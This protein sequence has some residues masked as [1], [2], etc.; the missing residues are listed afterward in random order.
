[1]DTHIMELKL[2][3]GKTTLVDDRD[4]ETIASYNWYAVKKP[5]QNY[6]A[7]SHTYVSGIRRVILMHRLILGLGVDDLSVDH[8]NGNGL[9]NRRCN[10]RLATT[11]QNAQN[12]KTH[13]TG[14]GKNGLKTSTYK[15]VY[16][17]KG[18]W[19]A[20]IRVGGKQIYL[21]LFEKETEAA[22]SY[23]MAALKYFGKYAKLNEI[24]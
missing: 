4:Y 10:L 23:N 5:G 17:S 3:Q 24:E 13:K 9:D 16:K 15:G 20:Q 21:G 1:M 12:Q 19:K 6:Y 14:R 7:A 8:I 11:T 2:T 18:K 22:Q